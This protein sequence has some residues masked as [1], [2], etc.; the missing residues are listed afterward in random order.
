MQ[1]TYPRGN[2]KAPSSAAP[3][4]RPGSPLLCHAAIVAREHGIPA[5]VA[6]GNAT[7]R[8]RDG[9]RVRVDGNGG[10]GSLIDD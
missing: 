4:P 5:V 2:A 6:T 10:S 9:Q 7:K 3:P 1:T 8:S